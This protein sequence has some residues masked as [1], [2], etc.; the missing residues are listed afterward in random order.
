MSNASGTQMSQN[1]GKAIGGKKKLLL[2]SVIFLLPFTIA[3]TMHL[4]N[5][6]PASHSYGELIAP[7]QALKIP[8]LTDA[9]G[10]QLTAQQWQKIWSIV[11]IDSTGCAQACQAQV[12]LLK[13]LQLTLDKDAK[14]VQRILLLPSDVQATTL[15]ALQT[16]YPDLHIFAGADAATIAFAKAFQANVTTANQTTSNVYLVDPLGNLMMR[17]AKNQNPK[18]MQ[19][20]IKRLLKNSWAG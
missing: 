5:F 11:M 13:Q 7:P 18:G 20:D 6:K 15:N 2:L 16:Q 8:T 10:K 1:T 19:S 3:A 17:Y 9:Q 4:L 14:R 12:H